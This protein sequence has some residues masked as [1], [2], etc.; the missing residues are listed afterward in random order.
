MKGNDK[1]IEALNWRLAEELGAINQ[2]MVHAEMCANWGYS[3]LSTHMKMTARMEMGH[4]EKLIERIIFLEGRPD[5]KRLGPIHIG[6]NVEDMHVQDLAA[7]TG[8]V[9]KYNATVELARKVND[10]VTR[11]LLEGI[12]IDENGHVDYIEAAMDQIVQMGIQNYLSTQV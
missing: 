12:L 2:Y 7:E 9:E 4:A 6:I 10:N 8:A 5:V 11:E 3:T 1:L